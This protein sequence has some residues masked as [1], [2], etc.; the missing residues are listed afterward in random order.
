[1]RPI[2]GLCLLAMLLLMAAGVF[3]APATMSV[4]VRE[5]QLRSTPSFLGKVVGQLAYGDRV[6]KQASQGAWMKVT[7]GDTVGWVH[8]SALT[9]KRI[10]L[11]AGQT[12]AQV[13]ASSDE[14]ALAGKGFNA[15]V[16]KRFKADHQNVDF[17]WIDWMGT[18]RI[19]QGEMQRFLQA[20]GLQPPAGGVQ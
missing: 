8:Q 16:E 17:S 7:A 13:T 2:R 11:T 19:E 18:L 3:S 1:M 10:V 5:T 12:D 14:V 15:D 6:I 9:A 20:G 4:Q